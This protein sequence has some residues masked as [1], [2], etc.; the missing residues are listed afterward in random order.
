M[1]QVVNELHTLLQNAGVEGPYILV[2][3]SWGG[4]LMRLYTDLYQEEVV[5]LVLV[6]SSH[7]DTFQRNLAVLPPESPDDS[8]SLKFYRNW[9]SSAI[10]DP[11]IKVDPELYETGSLGDLPLVVLTAMNKQ[12]ANDFP[13]DLNAKFNEIW[14]EL[15]KELAQLSSN[16]THIVSQESEH[17]IQ[18][19]QPALVI[20][21][22]LQ[23]VNEVR[24]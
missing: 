11:T 6:D 2:G 7:P 10:N 3:H 4:S 5:G 20:D 17:Y 13:A 22:I 8:E 9:F 12:R 23:V 1:P 14:L 19:E 15:Q 21:A 24:H 18:E 16:S